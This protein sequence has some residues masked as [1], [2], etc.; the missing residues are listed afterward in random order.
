MLLP[1]KIQQLKD[2]AEERAGDYECNDSMAALLANLRDN[3]KT[4]F[5][6]PSGSIARQTALSLSKMYEKELDAFLQRRAKE[7]ADT[8]TKLF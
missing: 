8:Q 1:T 4:F 2:T 3:Q 5:K 6:S 7:K